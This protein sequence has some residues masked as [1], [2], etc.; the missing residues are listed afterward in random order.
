MNSWCVGNV[1]DMSGLFYEMRS[2]NDDISSLDVG[3]V[4]SMSGMFAEASS[5]NGDLS[6]WDVSKV[7]DMS[8]MFSHT[9]NFNGN[10]SA[11]VG[12]PQVPWDRCMWS[13]SRARAPAFDND[14]GGRGR[15]ADGC[16]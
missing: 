16:S 12:T 11:V 15:L 1:T 5:F 6:S 13:P 8:D 2:F 9:K 4:Q 14:G 10:I 7:Q 3:Q